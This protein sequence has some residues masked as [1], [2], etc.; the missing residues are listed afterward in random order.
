MITAGA[1]KL[2]IT[3]QLPQGHKPTSHKLKYNKDETPETIQK[4]TVSYGTEPT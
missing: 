2:H 3:Y 4:S 1:S